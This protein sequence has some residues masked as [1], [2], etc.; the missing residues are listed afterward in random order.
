MKRRFMSVAAVALAVAASAFTTVKPGT[1]AN[2][3]SLFW[4]QVDYSNN[5]NGV[6]NSSDALYDH[7][8]KTDVDSPCDQGT[9]R[10]CLRGFTSEISSFPTTNMGTDQIKRDN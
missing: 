10:D 7:A 1:T 3:A 5:P 4:Y 6:I 2:T 9:V 8:E